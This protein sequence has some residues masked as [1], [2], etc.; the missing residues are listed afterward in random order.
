MHGRSVAVEA[1]TTFFHA[2]GTSAG[3]MTTTAS[4]EDLAAGRGLGP[5]S[6][7]ARG[8]AACR[9]GLSGA[10]Q[11]LAPKPLAAQVDPIIPDDPNTATG[12]S[13]YL[14]YA[15]QYE[16]AAASLFFQAGLN[17]DACR[18][19][20]PDAC[21]TAAAQ[22]RQASLYQQLV[23][24][25]FHAW[26][27]CVAGRL[28]P[29]EGYGGGTGTGG[30]FEIGGGWTGETWTGEGG[31]GGGG[32]PTCQRY[33]VEVSYDGGATWMEIASFSICS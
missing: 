20:D 1:V 6:G 26:G 30:G 29:P 18:G 7:L 22:L 28:P 8:L 25:M 2:D 19:G 13:R 21:R 11:A 32:G 3:E 16:L 9:A 15:A 12:C 14:V 31:G 24:T 23:F 17:A 27:E 4:A 33:V 10:A 5:A